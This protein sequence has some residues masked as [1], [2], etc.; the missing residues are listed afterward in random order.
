MRTRAGRAEPPDHGIEAVNILCPKVSQK[1]TEFGSVLQSFPSGQGRNSIHVALPDL[2]TELP[3][4]GPV[5]ASP[6]LTQFGF[7]HRKWREGTVS[8]QF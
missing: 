3:K 4:H 5:P 8:G 7:K 2:P 6:S 1:A